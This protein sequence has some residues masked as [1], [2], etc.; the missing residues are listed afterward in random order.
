MD[1]QH[2]VPP[3]EQNALSPPPPPAI[4]PEPMPERSS[5][6]WWVIMLAIASS[7]GAGAYH[8]LMW[9]GYGHSAAMFLGLPAILA[10]LLALTPKAKSLTGSVMKGITLALLIVAPLVG[11]GYLCILIA[12]P[13]FYAVGGITI[14]IVEAIGL[15]I[16]RARGK[17]LSCIAVVLLPMCLEGVV[18]QLTFDRHQTVRATAIVNGN[19]AEVAA[20]LAASP[21]IE[22]RL[23]MFLRTGFPRPLVAYGGG[24]NLGDRRV[25]HFSGAE[26]DPPGDLVMQ[27]AT[28]EPGYVRF[29]TIS[30]TSKL[31]QWLRWNSSEV[32]WSA[33]DPQHTRLTWTVHFERGLDPAW[34]FTPWERY[35]VGKAAQYLIA[36]N[37]S[38]YGGGD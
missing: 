8:G 11:E 32:T 29:V 30:D 22:T 10:I 27:V 7:V 37:A 12:A 28:R 34:Y 14:V 33:L 35:A 1:E 15:W 31:T 13:L 17:T 16:E 23:P 24:L 21:R 2:S 4:E 3:D 9:S 19:T 38:P 26:G 20:A 6:R 25:I 36:A 5:A 18:P